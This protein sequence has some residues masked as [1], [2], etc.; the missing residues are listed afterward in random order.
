MH[1]PWVFDRGQVADVI[2]EVSRAA[3]GGA[4]AIGEPVVGV[5]AVNEVLG[6]Q[7]VHLVREAV[8]CVITPERVLEL[9]INEVCEIARGIVKELRDLPVGVG[10]G[11]LAPG[12]WSTGNEADMSLF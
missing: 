5:I 12:H 4:D 6:S 10:F 2:V 7:V 11:Y 3:F 8:K 1:R 9:G